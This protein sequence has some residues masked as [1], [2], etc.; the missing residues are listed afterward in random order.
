M[1]AVIST[2]GLFRYRLDR[3]VRDEGPVAAYFGVNGSTADADDEDHTTRKWNG[4]SQRNAFSRYIVGNPFAYR[5]RDVRQ[6]ALV[7]D[8]VGPEN[9]LYLQEIIE[10]A[11]ILIPCWGNRSKVPKQLHFHIDA[12]RDLIVAAG[13]PVLCF[14]YTKSRDPIHPLTLDYRTP[15]VP[16]EI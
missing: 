14:G 6:L 4:F 8:P 13:K 7:P 9:F 15:L 3:D 2:C 12:L 10:E 1:S 5:A 11:D 16:F